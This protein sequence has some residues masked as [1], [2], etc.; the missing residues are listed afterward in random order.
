MDPS[1]TQTPV[2]VLLS[3]PVITR[4]IRPEALIFQVLRLCFHLCL[5][6]GSAK[7]TKMKQRSKRHNG[8]GCQAARGVVTTSRQCW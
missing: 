2:V 5:F 7:E 6:K 8:P 4:T 3:T 1:L